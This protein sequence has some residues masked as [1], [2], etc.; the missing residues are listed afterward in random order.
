MEAP[1]AHLAIRSYGFVV[2]TCS[3]LLEL[4]E[5]CDV[6]RFR[7]PS[8]LSEIGLNCPDLGQQVRY[9]WTFR[10]RRRQATKVGTHVPEYRR[11]L[12]KVPGCCLWR[13]IGRELFVERDQS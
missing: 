5:C 3:S 8:E 6:A 10:G 2:V 7:G 4:S 11:H 12:L 13:R 9:K 1:S